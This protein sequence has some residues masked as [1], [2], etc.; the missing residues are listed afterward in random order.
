MITAC[1][2]IKS[3]AN[4]CLNVFKIKEIKINTFYGM[5]LL[6]AVCRLVGCLVGWLAVGKDVGFAINLHRNIH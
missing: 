3:D 6:N 4:E 2:H 5:H 1:P